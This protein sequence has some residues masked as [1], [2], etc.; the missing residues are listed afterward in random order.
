[1]YSTISPLV[2]ELLRRLKLGFDILIC[3]WILKCVKSK[4]EELRGHK[5]GAEMLH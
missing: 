1:M 4:I 2:V 5:V 3:N